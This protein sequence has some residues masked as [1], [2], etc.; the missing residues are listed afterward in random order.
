LIAVNPWLLAA[1]LTLSSLPPTQAGAAADVS[2]S[3]IL[4]LA[5]ES[6]PHSLDPTQIF[7][8]EEAMLAH[9]VFAKLYDPL[10]EG[11][12]TP[13]IAKSLPEPGPD[14]RTY[15]LRLRSGVRFST[16]RELEAADVIHTFERAF[17]P[18]NGAANAIYFRSLLGVPAFETARKS[19][20]DA[21]RT[22]AASARPG[23]W[24]EPIS[25]PGIQALDRFTVRVVLDKPDL[26]FPLIL[27]TIPAGIVPR[28]E[29]LRLGSR[30]ASQP[31]GAGPFQLQ[32]WTR[33]ARMQFVRN[34]HDFQPNPRA[35]QRVDVLINIDRPT[36]SML[37]ERGELDFQHYLQGP[38]FARIRHD[39]A[40]RS[41]LQVV[42]GSTPTFVF[43]NCEIP[44]F[45][46]RLV[47]LA[48]NH[49]LDKQAL[50]K[51]LLNRGVPAS[52]PL[53]LTVHGFNR[54][55]P[56]YHHDPD[57][58]RDLLRQA[59]F[60]DGFDT[61]LWT[62]RDNPLWVRIA[63]FVQAGLARIGVRAQLKEVSTAAY[64]ASVGRRGV[65]PMGVWDWLT[66][67]NDP[68]ETLDTLYNGGNITEEGCMNVSFY[69]DPQVNQRFVDALSEADA[70]RRLGIYRDIE[71]SIVRDL[72]CIFLV[73]INTE[74][75]LHPR[76][77]GFEARGFWPP[78]HFDR[79]WFEPTPP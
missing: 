12:M 11:G 60:P 73:Q 78:A 46:N 37:F 35:P 8:N 15:T 61:V 58:A 79:V 16:G 44:P 74:M 50:C 77:R 14:G 28:D 55:L 34:L 21:R 43:L 41:T 53:P 52:G 6:D 22:N 7:T 72:P 4:Q 40:A 13:V 30:F 70:P 54:N 36:Q 48:L 66:T 23:R 75:R 20:T 49:A 25:L 31:V 68:K 39:P 10:P 38:D 24:I 47:R 56:E 2:R 29:T 67:F 64:L 63:H 65:V 59:G 51:V 5:V 32:S 45:T 62:N 42:Q 76:V 27:A 26:A 18:E 9:F 69:S 33:G 17:E 19:E 57:K 71:A 1:L 3:S